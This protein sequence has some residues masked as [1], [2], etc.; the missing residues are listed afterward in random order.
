MEEQGACPGLCRHALAFQEDL[1]HNIFTSDLVPLN[2][3]V[4]VGPGR[5]QTVRYPL[6]ELRACPFFGPDW[7][8]PRQATV[9]DVSR[10]GIGLLLDAP[11]RRG[12]H[13]C[14]ELPGRS[15]RPALRRSARVAHVRDRGAGTWAA[16]CAFDD[17]LPA[18]HREALLDGG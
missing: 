1:M 13:V 16:G 12:D 17:P 10:G 15:G 5:R 14:I 6:V 2:P 18:E 3:G 11:V 9:Q 4:A 7:P 8:A